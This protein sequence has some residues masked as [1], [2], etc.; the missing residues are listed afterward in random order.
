M[1]F[2]SIINFFRRKKGKIKINKETDF[3]R[4]GKEEKLIKKPIEEEIKEVEEE[5]ETKVNE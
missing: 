3:K 5:I 2:R 4:V 1:V